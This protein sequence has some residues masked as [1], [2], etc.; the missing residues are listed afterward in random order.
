[1]TEE[2]DILTAHDAMTLIGP[3]DPVH[4][5]VNPAGGVLVGADWTRAEILRLLDEAE[6]VELGGPECRRIEHPVVATRRGERYFI[7]A[8]DR[9]PEVVPMGLHPELA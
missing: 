3:G 8:K 7:A 5:L 6:V 2:R 9:E 4:V 1:M